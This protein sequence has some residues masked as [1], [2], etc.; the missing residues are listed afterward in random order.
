ML[1]WNPV[2]LDFASIPKHARYMKKLPLHSP[3]LSSRKAPATKDARPVHNTAQYPFLQDVMA[4][5]GIERGVSWACG[6]GRSGPLFPIRCFSS[7]V[8]SLWGDW[9][10]VGILV[11]WC[12]LGLGLEASI[13]G[14]GE[15]RRRVPRPRAREWSPLVQGEKKYISGSMLLHVIQNCA[16]MCRMA[17]S[18]WACRWARFRRIGDQ[19]IMKFN[20][21]NVVGA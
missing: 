1:A 10:E 4:Q 15:L 21:L 12:V 6:G 19:Q 11:G 14:E 18:R 5:G 13:G 3:T 2:P 20:T 17:S 8:R 7:R 16:C 9:L